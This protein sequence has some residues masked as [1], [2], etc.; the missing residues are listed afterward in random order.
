MPKRAVVLALLGLLAAS[1]S[2]APASASDG[3]A[4]ARPT[5]TPVPT[6]TAPSA[7]PPVEPDLPVRTD[8]Q[9]DVEFTVRPLNLHPDAEVLE[10]EVMMNTHSVDL[11]WDLA[12]RSTLKTDTGVEVDATSWPV[13]GGHHYGGT[14]VFPASADDGKPVLEAARTVTLV[15]RDTDVPERIFTW[16]LAAD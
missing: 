15:I 5:R 12:S 8:L 6:A 16:E 11:G 1:C 2:S 14:L 10:F 9:G 13:G 3:G 4:T 7:A